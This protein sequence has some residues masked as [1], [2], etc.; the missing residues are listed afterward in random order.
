[1]S[2]PGQAD[3]FQL[4]KTG[5]D[6]HAHLDLQQFSQDL[7]HVLERASQAGVQF[8]GNVFLNYQAYFQ[9]KSLFA[10][11][12]QVFFLLG[13]HPH[14]AHLAQPDQLQGVR[15]AFAQDQRL[16]ALGEIGLD[17]YRLR[18]PRQTQI[19]AFQD[20]LTLARELDLPVVLH[21]R[22]AESKT[23]QILQD[24]GFKHRPLLWHCF[25][26]NLDLARTI[27]A[28]GW[29]ISI[30]GIISFPQARELQ[31]AV[32]QLPLEGLLLETDCPFLAPEPY[33]GARNEPAFLPYTACKVAELQ[34]VSLE[35]VWEKTGTNSRDFFG[36]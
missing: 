4:P 16:L 30:P 34:Q 33:R 25:G 36:F 15:Q 10:G 21:C 12:E 24:L 14:D 11:L 29:K 27:L 32:A 31:G 6:T 8:M 20:Q 22:D 9:S 7:P 17:F 13:V 23:L 18:Q 5:I 2:A 3:N 26:K 1:M 19:Q 35:E 28:K